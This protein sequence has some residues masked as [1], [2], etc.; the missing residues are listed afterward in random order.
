M[1]QANRKMMEITDFLRGLTFKKRGGGVDKEDVLDKIEQ[2]TLLYH[3]LLEEQSDAI[4][5]LQ[6]QNQLLL[7]RESS[8]NAALQEA[9][10]R[11]L[12]TEDRLEELSAALDAA[13][14]EQR[15]AER[16]LAALQ[17]VEQQKAEKA[18]AQ[19]DFWGVPA[20]MAGDT[21]ATAMPRLYLQTLRAE[22]T[23]LEERRAEL[24]RNL[25]AE[26]HALDAI[27]RMRE[28]N[29]RAAAAEQAKL[30]EGVIGVREEC[31]RVISVL[32]KLDGT[33]TA[34]EEVAQ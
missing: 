23:K 33:M 28:D 4:E 13:I 24:E 11:L 18:Q 12:V 21:E 20:A 10:D 7:E 2:L 9:D 3:A 17:A 25:I 34:D 30:R 15:D 5:Y 8:A 19:G 1:E 27:R 6:G 31:L 22:I 14:S 26:A 32:S 29:R 16:K